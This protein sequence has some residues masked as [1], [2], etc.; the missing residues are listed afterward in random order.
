MGGLGGM[1]REAPTNYTR[2]GSSARLYVSS[3]WPRGTGLAK[4]LP[5]LSSRRGKPPPPQQNSHLLPLRATLPLKDT[6][7][8]NC[9]HLSYG[10]HGRTLRPSTPHKKD[11]EVFLRG[12]RRLVARDLRYRQCFSM[13]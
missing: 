10:P 4:L 2:Q 6:I 3:R 11:S 8:L 5:S 9:K 7:M 1:L 12:A 13:R